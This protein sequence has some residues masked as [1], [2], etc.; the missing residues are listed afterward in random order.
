MVKLS[1]K[2]S[3]CMLS[4]LLLPF[5]FSCDVTSVCVLYAA[6]ASNQREAAASRAATAAGAGD[7]DGG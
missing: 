4:V 5:C 2:T 3:T 6:S 7:V 1:Y